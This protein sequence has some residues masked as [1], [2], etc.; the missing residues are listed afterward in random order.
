M[1]ILNSYRALIKGIDENIKKIN[2]IVL[3]DENGLKYIN[4]MHIEIDG[5]ILNIDVVGVEKSAIMSLIFSRTLSSEIKN[6]IIGIDYGEK[7]GLAVLVNSDIVF[8]NSYRD[9]A[10]VLKIIKMFIN[11]IDSAR[12]IVRIGLPTK[13][14]KGYNDFVN[15]L[16][17]LLGDNVVIEFISENGSSRRKIGINGKKIDEDSLAAINIALQRVYNDEI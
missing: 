17:N 7:I 10:I 16:T 14:H 1:D 6:I 13:S 15:K 11:S 3:V 9:R 12:K 2:G 8:I 4:E 5:M